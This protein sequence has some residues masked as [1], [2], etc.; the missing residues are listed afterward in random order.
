MIEL[1]V[2]TPFVLRAKVEVYKI[3]KMAKYHKLL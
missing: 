3:P 1:K 2:L